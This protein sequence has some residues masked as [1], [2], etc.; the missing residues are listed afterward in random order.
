M[1]KRYVQI[2]VIKKTE[3]KINSLQKIIPA[4]TTKS[5][6]IKMSVDLSEI[7]SNHISSGGDVILRDKEGNEK[8]LIIK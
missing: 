2:Q 4:P 5:D 7:V 8:R 6:I 1:D 3:D